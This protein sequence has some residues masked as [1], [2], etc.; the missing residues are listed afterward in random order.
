MNRFI[1][2]LTLF[3]LAILLPTFAEVLGEKKCDLAKVEKGLYCEEHEFLTVKELVSSVTYYQCDDCD[4]IHT[5]SGECE[6]CEIVL[7]KK[8]SGKNVCPRCY[9]KPEEIEVCVKTCYE[10]PECG[11][12]SA[13]AG[14][15]EDCEKPWKKITVKARV[16]YECPV[17]E[18]RELEPG[19]CTDEDCKA[20]DKP[21][22]KV[23]SESGTFPH[24]E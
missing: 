16:E 23:C 18:A 5:K 1:F 6:D 17:C 21:L 20:F 14:E 8:V 15:C 9:V 7:T 19:N 11:E 24:G 12:R 22:V 13:A 2:F 3:S 10:C 4:E